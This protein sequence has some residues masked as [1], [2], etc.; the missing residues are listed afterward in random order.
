MN[1]QWLEQRHLKQ[2]TSGAGPGHPV[3]DQPEFEYFLALERKR[4]DRSGRPFLLLLVDIRGLQ[5]AGASPDQVVVDSIFSA[6]SETL[7]DT[8]HI[9]WYRS[10]QIA[11]SVLTELGQPSGE[12]T[13]E[14]IERKVAF[15]LSRCLPGQMSDRI[16]IS[17]FPY[18][19]L[20]Y[21]S[22]SPRD[23]A[24]SRMPSSA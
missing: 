16:R 17:S 22:P 4:S 15:G 21:T 8:D 6:L 19:C 10:G 2:T 18:P 3:L 14:A 7:R 5:Q 12:S 20:L 24:T 9:G 23:G 11:G 1:T 13:C